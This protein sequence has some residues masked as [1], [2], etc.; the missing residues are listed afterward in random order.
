[1]SQSRLSLGRMISGRG[2]S[3]R[4][5]RYATTHVPRKTSFPH[6]PCSLSLSLS[7]PLQLNHALPRARRV[8]QSYATSIFTTL[9]SFVYTFILMLSLQL[10][11]PS[12]LLLINGPG[13]S[14]VLAF[15]F[16]LCNLLLGTKTRVVMVESWCRVTGLSL[17]G[18]LVKPIA[19]K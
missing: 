2:R 14:L 1:M 7:L 17:T 13:T 6:R 15:S 11:C 18:K 3:L 8:K 9:Y 12:A 19:D 16:K 10:S 4:F 5:T